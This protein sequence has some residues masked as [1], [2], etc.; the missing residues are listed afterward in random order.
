MLGSADVFDDPHWFWS[1]Q[2]D[3]KV[4]MAGFAPT[5]DRMIVR[6]SLEDRSFCAFLL[7][8]G[9][10]LR[11]T[12]SLDRKRDV[13]RSFGSIKAQLVPDPA[14]LADP[15]VDLRKLVEEEGEVGVR[16]ARRHAPRVQPRPPSADPR[17]T[18]RCRWPGRYEAGCGIADRLAWSTSTARSSVQRARTSAK[19]SGSDA[20]GRGTPELVDREVSCDLLGRAFLLHDTV[21]EEHHAVRVAEGFGVVRR[22]QHRAVAPDHVPE[23]L[24]DDVR[25]LR[26]DLGDRLVGHH[27]LGLGI[28]ARATA[29]RCCCPADSSYV[30]LC[31]RVSRPSRWSH[32]SARSRA[33][34]RSI[35]FTRSGRLHILDRGERRE[36]PEALEHDA[37][38]VLPELAALVARHRRHRPALPLHLAVIG[39]IEARE[40]SQE[41]RLAR[42]ARSHQRH[43]VPRP[44]RDGGTAPR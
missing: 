8:D 36:Q 44:D 1:D 6:G 34:V 25:V 39:G 42:A 33:S 32:P 35:P 41:R 16:L 9:G 29:T 26:V 19:P 15:D 30:R 14:L 38:A 21:A 13:R 43:E 2:Y 28:S 5:W 10:V 12:V 11:S 27:D 4:E 31:I 23:R 37:D 3:S 7:D 18:A 40:H 24:E 20:R 17:R 22:G